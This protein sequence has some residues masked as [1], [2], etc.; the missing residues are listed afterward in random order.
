MRTEEQCKSSER[1]LY[2]DEYFSDKAIKIWKAE[3]IKRCKDK[4]TGIPYEKY[5]NWTQDENE[6]AV[7]TMYAYADFK[8]P[9]RF[10]IIFQLDNPDDFIEINYELI[11][12][13]HEAW[14]PLETVDHGHKHLC[15]LKFES[16]VPDILRILHKGEEKFSTV[17]KEQPNLGFC[18]SKDFEQIKI[19]I[20]KMINLKELHGDKWRE[21]DDGE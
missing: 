5:I 16:A 7:F 14:L 18:N 6:I 1:F 21:H 10:D 8:I 20:K 2:A 9:K 12:S 13:I 11:Q 19:R 15:I 3:S 4:V 17:P